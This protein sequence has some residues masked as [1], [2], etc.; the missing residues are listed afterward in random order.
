MLSSAIAK[1]TASRSFLFQSK[2]FKLY[3]IVIPI[4][5]YLVY[6]SSICF[7]CPLHLF[8]HVRERASYPSLEKYFKQIGTKPC[9]SSGISWGSIIDPFGLL[10]FPLHR[11]ETIFYPAFYRF[12]RGFIC[13][14]LSYHLA[15]SD[16]RLGVKQLL[17]KIS[18]FVSVFSF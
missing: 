18:A 8:S 17:F 4:C 10:S 9:S 12:S 6:L 15:S 16:L 14:S 1:V 13:R 2:A 11:C 7:I 3:L 5:T